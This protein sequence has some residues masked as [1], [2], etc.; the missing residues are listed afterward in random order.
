[1]THITEEGQPIGMFYGFKVAG[2]VTEADMA[3]LDD[4]AVYKANGN[5][6]PE[7]YELQGDLLVHYSVCSSSAW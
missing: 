2:M 6:F 4:D 3:G 5:S 7:G 1:M